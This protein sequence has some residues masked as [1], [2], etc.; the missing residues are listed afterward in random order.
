MD[1]LVE[2]NMNAVLWQIRQGGTVYYNSSFEPWGSRAGKEYPGYDPLAYAIEEAH[3][4]GLELHA[5]FNVFQV[6]NVDPTTD[7]L[8]PALQHPDWV[9]RDGDGNPMPAHRSFSP[10]LDSVRSYTVDVAMEIVNNYDIDGLHLDYVRWNEY[11]SESVLTI[12]PFEAEEIYLVDGINYLDGIKYKDTDDIL[13][14]FETDRYLWDVEHPYSAG[15]PE[16]YDSWENYWR[17][18]VTEFVQTLHDSIQTVKP[19]VRL[20]AAALGKYD[21]SGWNG[22]HIVFQDAALWFNQGYIDQLTPMHYHWSTAQGFY[23]MLEGDCPTNCWGSKLDAG[24]AAGRLFSV[25]PGSYKFDDTNDWDNHPSIVERCRTIEWTD[26]FQFYDYESWQVHQYWEDARLLFFRQKTKVRA[27]KFLLDEQPDSPSISAQKLDSLTYEIT[28]TP[29]VSIATNQRF[30]IYRSEDDT[31]DVETDEI[32]D[33]HFGESSYTFID[34]LNGWQNFDGQYTYYA[35]M[36]DRYWNE[37]AVSNSYISDLIPSFPPLVSFSDPKQGDT[38]KVNTEI[39]IT[40]T[41]S[42]DAAT[43]T[44]NVSIEP[45]IP[46]LSQNW[47]YNHTI[48]HL[49]FLNNFEHAMDYEL[50][51]SKDVTDLIGMQLDGNGDG[52]AGDDFLLNFRTRDEDI[53]GPIPVYY[54]PDSREDTTGADIADIIT[55]A[56]DELIDPAMVNESTVKVQQEALDIPVNISVFDAYNEQS[57]ITLQADQV[58]EPARPYRVAF[59]QA[60]ADI[61]GN[62]MDSTFYLEFETEPFVYSDG[63]MID[64]F[65]GSGAWEYPT[66]S[67]STNGV[68]PVIS[69]FQITG[70]PYLPITQNNSNQKKSGELHYVWSSTYLDPPGSEYLLREYLNVSPPR[71]VTFDTTYILQC[72]VFGDGSGNKFR[73]AVDDK[74]P[75]AAGE[76]HEVSPWYTINWIGWKLISW[77]LTE[78]KTGEWVGDGSL[79]GTLRMDSFQLTHEEGAAVSGTIF[80]KYLRVMKKEYNTIGDV[81]ENDLIL[82]QYQLSQNYPNPFNPTTKIDFSLAE[83]GETSLIIYDILGRRVKMLIN[84]NLERGNHSVTFDG[85]NLASGVYIYVLRSKNIVMQ[86]KMMLLK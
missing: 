50:A 8:P 16:G 30:A 68:T 39:K 2:A 1:N 32:I 15:I 49:S 46:I 35:T 29:P 34:S 86:K 85:S 4:R 54:N 37:S 19:Y 57:V 51:I 82:F 77:D 66:Y 36:F 5:W 24:I 76:N 18:A 38:I 14:Y 65:T 56:F 61:A 26:G 23:D 67:G 40:F 58:L 73:F 60:I 31:L 69:Y 59:D 78:G 45:E 53:S 43:F 74:V 84:E 72:Y 6:S 22:Y 11:D 63:M 79:D 64:D 9:C 62:P 44:D 42:M 71:E 48:L 75:E 10:G 80:F 3:K 7:P 81:E 83:G 55:L 70:S 25:G 17:W 41:K 47:E 12:A 27:A 28:V 21:W 13:F 33:V 52:I 20:S